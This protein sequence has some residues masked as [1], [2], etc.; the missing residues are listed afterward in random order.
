MRP[1][2]FVY[3]GANEHTKL[4]S[5]VN[6]KTSFRFEKLLYYEENYQK[7]KES[8][9]ERRDNSDKMYNEIVYPPG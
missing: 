8:E 1:A 3:F 6:W 2:I 4:K 7:G 5:N 9:R